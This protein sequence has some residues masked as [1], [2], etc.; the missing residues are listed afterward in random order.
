M[1]M[2]NLI[3]L[4]TET[5]DA[6]SFGHHIKHL[7]AVQRK[8][9]ADSQLRA[10]IDQIALTTA[11]IL[12]SVDASQIQQEATGAKVQSGAVPNKEYIQRANEEFI[13]A[14]IEMFVKQHPEEAEKIAKFKDYVAQLDNRINIAMQPSVEKATT[15]AIKGIQL[16]TRGEIG[17]LDADIEA[18]ALAF[19]QEF[20]LKPIWA[21]NLIGMFSI[22][23]PHEDRVKFLQACREKNPEKRAINIK[24][25][26]ERGQ[27]RIEDVVNTKLPKVAEV[28]KSVKNTLLDISLSTGQR[29]A[30]GPFEAVLAIMGGAKKPKAD[31]GGDIVFDVDGRRF[32]IEVKGGSLTPNTSLIKKTGQLANTGGES[33]A[34]LDSTANPDPTKKGGELGGSVLRSVGD[35]WLKKNYP[36]ATTSKELSDYWAA[37]DFRSSSLPNLSMF[38]NL[39]EKRKP[40]S[41]TALITHMMATMFPSATTAPKFNFKKS[42]TKILDGIHSNNSRAVAKEQGTMALIEYAL[43]KGNDGFI[44]FNSSTQEY[45]MVMGIEGILKVYASEEGNEDE[46]SVRFLEPMTMKRGAAKCSPSVYFGPAAKGNRAKEYFT[47]FNKSPERVKLRQDMIAKGDPEGLAAQSAWADRPEATAP[48]AKRV[49][50]AEPKRQRR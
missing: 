22:A 21:R 35:D 36:T 43:G 31:E 24:S 18:N 38:L 40:G 1:K 26:M 25:M 29:G 3:N 33:S 47:E 46:S 44:F 2:R 32:K 13:N 10:F 7:L 20:G 30:T 39:I 11:E 17:A 34:W 41:S 5:A 6:G 49:T 27:G 12:A 23:I 19:A 4:I 42:I 28:F 8:L 15:A 16:N 37:A 50:A 45:K 48:R 9:P 14:A